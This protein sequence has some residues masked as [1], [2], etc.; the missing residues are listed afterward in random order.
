MNKTLYDRAMFFLDLPYPKVRLLNTT[1]DGYL[2]KLIQDEEADVVINI[3]EDAFVLDINLLQDLL[4]YCIDNQYVNC[5]MPDG[6]IVEIR[7]N[8]PL[9]TNPYFNILNTKEIRKKILEFNSNNYIEHKDS[10]MSSYPKEILKGPYEFVNNEPYCPL[11]VWMSQNFKTLYLNAYEH[12]DGITTV[13]CNQED[14]PFI[15]HTWYSRFYNRDVKH[16]RR[17]NKI[18]KECGK[19][20]GKIYKATFFDCLNNT[21]KLYFRFLK[22]AI[23]SILRK[24]K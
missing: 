12:S 21:S 18:I 8:N 10:Y 15:H 11:L 4:K 24:L 17:I 14:K 20:R 3:D 9:V 16:T 22:S 23:I 2:L 1:A 5:G 19:L 13:L 7:R 6:G